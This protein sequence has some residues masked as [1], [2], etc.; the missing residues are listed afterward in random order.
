MELTLGT[1]LSQ[2]P[3][4]A[5]AVSIA[6]SDGRPPVTAAAT[7]ATPS[8]FLGFA[9]VGQAIAATPA[10]LE[11]VRLL[12]EYFSSLGD[13]RLAIATVYFTG[14]AFPQTDLRTLQVGG[15]VIYRALAGAARMGEAEFRRIASSHGD[16]GKTAF[17]VLDGRTTPEPFG[18]TD[19][20]EFFEQ[21]HKL[22]GPVAKKDALQNR[23]A[24]L[25]AREGQYVVK[26][27][28]GDLRIGLREGLVEEAITKAFA[29][30]LDEVKEANM[31][32]GDIGRTAVLAKTQKLQR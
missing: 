4:I 5:V 6:E 19:S 29:A 30:P 23:L 18:L 2:L 7:T 3:Y 26:I 25:T 16:A 20:Y 17:E 27:L 9:N 10:K 11:K 13:K 22:R 14:H 12:A 24:R 8:E 15:S 31:L 1:S 32:L 21:L 28:S